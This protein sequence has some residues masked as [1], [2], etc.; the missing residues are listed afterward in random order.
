MHGSDSEDARARAQITRQTSGGVSE[1][2]SL[3]RYIDLQISRA[4]T[5]EKIENDKFR[6]K[7]QVL[8]AERGDYEKSAVLRGEMMLNLKQLPTATAAPTMDQY[9]ALVKSYNSLLV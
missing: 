8:L 1:E 5:Q 2:Q 9:N 7:I 3:M 4:L 6:E